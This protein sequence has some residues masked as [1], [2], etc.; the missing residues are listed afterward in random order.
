VVAVP[1]IAGQSARSFAL[2][3]RIRAVKCRLLHKQTYQ[4]LLEA[5]QI[6]ASCKEPDYIRRSDTGF[7]ALPQP[8]ALTKIT[9]R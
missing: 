1:G 2:E 6:R 9:V 4:T 7:G 8:P 3:R 5:H